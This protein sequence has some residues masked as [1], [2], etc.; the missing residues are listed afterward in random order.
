MNTEEASASVSVNLRIGFVLRITVYYRILLFNW[1]RVEAE[2]TA[3]AQSPSL[4]RNLCDL[5][6][7]CGETLNIATCY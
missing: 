7:L 2:S 6:V 1:L 5:R 3:K 4:K